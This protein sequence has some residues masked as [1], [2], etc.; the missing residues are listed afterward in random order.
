MIV[1]LTS[2]ELALSKG[3]II[4]D[5]KFEFG[6]DDNDA[7]VLMDEVLTPDSSRYWPLDGY[8]EG[9]NPPSYDKQFVRDWL[10]GVLVEGR[11]W[12]KRA[13]APMLP[14]EVIANTASRYLEALR[15]VIG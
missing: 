8:V 15:C 4:A 9:G 6:L 14:G 12:D 13:P 7:L 2:A 3:L 5:T 11:P 10:E 1:K